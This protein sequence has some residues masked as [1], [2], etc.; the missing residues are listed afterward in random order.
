MQDDDEEEKDTA[1]LSMADIDDQDSGAIC[2]KTA[3]LE[4]DNP[5][6][7]KS[8]SARLYISD[9]EDDE[10]EEDGRLS[11]QDEMHEEEKEFFGLKDFI[12]NEAELSGSELG[13]AD[14]REEGEDDWEE[15]EGD[16]E[17]F[18]DDEVRDAK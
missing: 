7:R 17:V 8:K 1:R 11:D 15:E 16:K 10:P 9:E 5:A 3:L 18:D 2:P 12:E 6:R 13:S 14:E 4:D